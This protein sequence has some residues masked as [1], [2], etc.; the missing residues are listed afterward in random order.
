MNRLVCSPFLPVCFLARRLHFLVVFR[1]FLFFI[2]IWAPASFCRSSPIFA[3][4]ARK[5]KTITAA[6]DSTLLGFQPI[7]TQQ[8]GAALSV[9][10]PPFFYSSSRLC[11]RF[12]SFIM[13]FSTVVLVF[14]RWLFCSH[15]SRACVSPACLLRVSS[16]SA[17]SRSCFCSPQV[18]S[19]R[20]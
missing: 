11:R 2:F 8:A 19:L 1:W 20:L 6:R 16:V 10:S 4:R 18:G 13:V 17:P 15:C 7:R 3:A 12:P 14:W 5:E 9:T